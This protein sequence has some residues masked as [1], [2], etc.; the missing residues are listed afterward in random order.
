MVKTQSEDDRTMA[1]QFLSRQDESA[2][3]VL[4]RRHTPLLFRMAW[5][6]VSDQ[7]IASEIVQDTWIR[8]AEG[9]HRFRWG[10]S[11]T[12]WLVGIVINR[13]REEIRRHRTSAL[14]M[15]AAQDLAAPPTA[16]AERLDLDRAVALLPQGYREVFLLHD[17]EGYTHED[18]AQA[19]NIAAATSRSQLARARAF[20]RE[21]LEP[22]KES[23]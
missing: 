11:L 19:L 14:P 9:L 1:E 10:S 4:Y 18:I 20:L 23:K 6:M 21:R 2:F 5:R 17:V 12:T 15:D 3:L 8:A 7:Q 16:L 22:K 13:S